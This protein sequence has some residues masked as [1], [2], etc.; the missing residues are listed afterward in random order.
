MLPFR[1]I[2]AFVASL[3]ISPPCVFSIDVSAGHAQSTETIRSSL[4]KPVSRRFSL[5]NGDLLSSTYLGLREAA[6]STAKVVENGGNCY[7]IS[8]TE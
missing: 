1:R 7:N 2:G 3:L 8:I 5:V 6:N 4:E